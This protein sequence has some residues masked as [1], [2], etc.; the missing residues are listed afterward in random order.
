VINFRNLVAGAALLTLV[1][2]GSAQAAGLLDGTVTVGNYSPDL[3]TL[4]LGP[5]TGPTTSSIN[6]GGFGFTFTDNT[7]TYTDG[8]DGAYASVPPGGF[9]GFVLTFAGVPTISGVSLDPS[10]QQTPTELYSTANSVYIDFNGGSQVAGQTVGIDVSF[11][12][13]AGVPEP[14]SWALLLLGAGMIG[15]GLRMARRKDGLAF[16]PAS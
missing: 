9:N 7:I 13:S 12:T 11:G 10:S 4:V 2:G 1:C 5:N 3:S 8:Y 15:G 14:A 6:V 16:S